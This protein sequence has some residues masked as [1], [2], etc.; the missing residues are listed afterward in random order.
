MS[1]QL[2]P[3]ETLH[4]SLR[5][6]VRK[7][8]DAVLDELTAASKGPRDEVVH[9]ARKSL[10]KI[11]AVLRLVRPVIG[12]KVFRCENTCF[13]DAAQPLTEVRDARILIE[14]LDKLLQHFREHITGWSF[15]DVGQA[16]RDNLRAARKRVLDEHNAFAVLAETLSEA[17][18]RVKGWTDVPN[19]WSSVGAGLQDTCRQARA[20]FRDAAADPAV[21]KLH[22]WRKQVKYLRYQF[23][24]MQPLWPE[25]MEELADETDRMGD[26]LGDDHDLAVLRQMV[27][28]DPRPVA[29]D[30][31][32]ETL[33]ALIDRRRAELEQ[34]AL[35]LGERF[36]QD[37]PRELARRLK[38]YCKT[39]HG[40]AG[41]A[42][43]TESLPARA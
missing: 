1:F 25:R 18:G 7:Q 21:A 43:A 26:F 10:K 27:D 34:E 29:D 36:F 37:R 4:K 39:W 8:I 19:K 24:V 28:R 33:V 9:D 3:E 30:G 15:A 11:R 6:I 35:L 22:E 40:R 12:E 20:A 13:R 32:R 14:T 23:D 2:R 42:Q 5:R 31:E 41:P 17:R 38:G 16:L